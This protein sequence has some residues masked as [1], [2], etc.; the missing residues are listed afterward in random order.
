LPASSY[1]FEGFELDLKRY[2]LSRNGRALKLEKIPMELLI[3]LV[4]RNG[5]LVSRQEIVESLWGKDVFVDTEHSINTAVRKI[6]HALGD[7]PDNP[8]FVKTLVGKGYRFSATISSLPDQTVVSETKGRETVTAPVAA[9]GSGAR[10]LWLWG[11]AAAL[12]IGILFGGNVARLRDRLLGK[13]HAAQISSLAVIPLEDLSGDKSQEFFAD[14]MTDELITDLAQNS[15]L[16][17]ISRTSVMRYKGT[18][19]PLPEIAKELSVDAIVE[20]TMEKAGNRIRVRAQLIRASDDRHLWAESFERDL[21]DV[22][23]LESEVASSIAR[24]VQMKLLS[25]RPPANRKIIPAAY[26]AYLKGRYAWNRKGEAALQEGIQYFQQ[27]IALD[28]TYAEPYSGLADS[29][30]TLGYL[31]YLPPREAFPQARAAAEKALSLDGS[32][33]EPHAS[34]AYIHFYFD[35]NWTA[36]EAEFRKAIALNPNYATAHDYYSYFLM[37]MQRPEEAKAEIERALQLDPLSL[38]INTDIGFQMYY[39]GRY[40]AA[41]EQ[42]K[43]TLQMNPKFPLAHLWLGRSYQAKGMFEESMAEYQATDAALPNWVVTVAGIGNLQGLE[44]KVGDAHLT[45]ARLDEIAKNKYVTP[46]GVALV[47]V[48][49]GDKDEAFRWLDKAFDDRANWLV[50]LRFDP[51]WDSL[52]TDPRYAEMIRRMEFPGSMAVK[53]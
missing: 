36:A 41:I 23:G 42:L 15:N 28:P 5:D 10:K 37:G 24:Q 3:L 33:P 48:G 46:Y 8:R 35:W 30:T 21:S 49:L 19:K 29:Y 11:A 2:E 1:Q 34:L 22:L 31:S 50:W 45:L 32:L 16:R 40:D 47:Y 43:K 39:T 17:V 26:E 13:T 53:N 6:R 4:S 27:A 18:R 38:S 20:G 9:A 12:L 52:R 51:R 7:D 25:E 44:K 14:G